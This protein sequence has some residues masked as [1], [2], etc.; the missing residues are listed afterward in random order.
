MGDLSFEVGWKIDDVDGLSKETISVNVSLFATLCSGVIPPNGH[1]FGQI[2]QPMHNCSEIKAILDSG[3]TS[4]QS[5]PVLTTGHDFLHSCRHFYSSEYQKAQS[6]VDCHYKINDHKLHTF[7]L[8]CGEKLV[9]DRRPHIKKHTPK[10]ETYFICAHDGN[11]VEWRKEYLAPCIAKPLHGGRKHI[12]CKFI[13]HF[14]Q[15]PSWCTLE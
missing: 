1:F 5:L 9:S 10:V 14:Y 8:H 11:T 13:G 6:L 7:G 12:P 4:M 2:P 15:V 3:E